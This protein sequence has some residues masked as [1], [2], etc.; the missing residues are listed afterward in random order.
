MKILPR[1]RKFLPYL[2]ITAILD[3]LISY[4]IKA[5]WNSTLPEVVEGFEPITLRQAHNLL[6]MALSPLLF[7]MLVGWCV[8]L[9][10]TSK[11]YAPGVSKP[12]EPLAEKGGSE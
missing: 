2:A 4:Q 1:F 7:L 10:Q 8:Y 11:H 6:N 3:F 5:N 12:D 9:Y